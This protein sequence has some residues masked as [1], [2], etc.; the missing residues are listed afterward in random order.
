V[1][2]RKAGE[3]YILECS[4]KDLHKQVFSILLMRNLLTEAV[5][6]VRAQ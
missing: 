2:S 4:K 1:L 6:M 5:K 3:Y